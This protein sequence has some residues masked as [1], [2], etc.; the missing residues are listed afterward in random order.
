MIKFEDYANEFK[1]LNINKKEGEIILNFLSK[2][3]RL[4]IETY[5]G[6]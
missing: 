3:I 1:Q 5:N 4:S 2:I 6:K